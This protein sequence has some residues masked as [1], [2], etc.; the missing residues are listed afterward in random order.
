MLN[1][2]N[3]PEIN[4]SPDIKDLFHYFTINWETLSPALWVLYGVLIA[5]FFL[6]IIKKLND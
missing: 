1:S 3:V 2:E 6:G 5:F 4:Y